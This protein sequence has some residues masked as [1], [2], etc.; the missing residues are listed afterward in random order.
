MPGALCDHQEVCVSK[1]GP[2]WGNQDMAGVADPGH[3]HLGHSFF[4]PGGSV[5]SSSDAESSVPHLTVKSEEGKEGLGR[6]WSLALTQPCRE[7]R[8][9]AAG[10]PVTE[11]PPPPYLGLQLWS[12]PWLSSHGLLTIVGS[13]HTSAGLKNSSS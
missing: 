11:L 1:V 3:G 13:R 2:A 10:L 7:R 12:P 5:R 6:S 8:G 9:G 4:L